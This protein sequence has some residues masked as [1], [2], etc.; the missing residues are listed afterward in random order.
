M[1]KIHL[2]SVPIKLSLSYSHKFDVDAYEIY[3]FC[4]R[5]YFQEN[6]GI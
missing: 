3:L 5:V 4:M 6:L 1:N 2:I